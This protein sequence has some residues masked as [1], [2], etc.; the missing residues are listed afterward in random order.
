V[1]TG[2]AS[3]FEGKKKTEVEQAVQQF[4]YKVAL[5]SH[6]QF[7]VVSCLV[8]QFNYAS[9]DLLR[10]MGKSLWASSSIDLVWR[11]IQQR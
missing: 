8:H 4:S 11:W 3:I 1:V 10:R 2:R 9:I 5:R 7:F 6:F